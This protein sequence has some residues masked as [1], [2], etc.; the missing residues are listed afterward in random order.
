MS[1]CEIAIAANECYKCKDTHV[2]VNK[3]CVE[4]TIE[5]CKIY[6]SSPS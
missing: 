6:I 4:K 1:N 5:N 2:N 3:E